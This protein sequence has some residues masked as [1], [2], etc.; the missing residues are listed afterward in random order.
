MYDFFQKKL[1]FMDWICF[2]NDVMCTCLS[3]PQDKKFY[4]TFVEKDRDQVFL[5]NIMEQKTSTI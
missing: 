1:V 3:L 4:N 5:D 2:C